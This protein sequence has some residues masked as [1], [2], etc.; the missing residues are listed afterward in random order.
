MEFNKPRYYGIFNFRLK[1]TIVSCPSIYYIS[2]EYRP[3]LPL[4]LLHLKRRRS[5]SNTSGLSKW[6]IK[7]IHHGM[8]D[9]TNCWLISIYRLRDCSKKKTM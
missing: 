5:L 6:I 7:F 1:N 3:P 8:N 4:K 2:K 9:I